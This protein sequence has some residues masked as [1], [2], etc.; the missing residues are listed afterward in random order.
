M[1]PSGSGKSTLL[2]HMIGLVPP[3]RGD[4]YYDHTSFWTADAQ[5]GSGSCAAS[6]SSTRKARSGAP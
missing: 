4:V 3:A 2:R 1:G 5:V 6:V